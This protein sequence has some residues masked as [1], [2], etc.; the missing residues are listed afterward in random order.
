MAPTSI[1]DL[2]KQIEELSTSNRNLRWFTV[3][4]FLIIIAVYTLSANWKKD[5]PYTAK[6]T[7][8]E[9]IIAANNYRDSI[10][11]DDI[12]YR[13]IVDSM[14]TMTIYNSLKNT[15]NTLANI[16]RKYEK[17]RITV[18]NSTPDELL[19]QFTEWLSSTDSL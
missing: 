16:T 4:M 5:D 17:Q 11:I 1:I 19:S 13:G 9:N 6:I 2:Q 18:D 15:D 12:R 7:E 8:L 10:Q 14:R 3:I